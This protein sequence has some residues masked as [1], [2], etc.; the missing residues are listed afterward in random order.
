MPGLL[1][2]LSVS[3]IGFI[4]VFGYFNNWKYGLAFA[5]GHLIPDL[6]DFGTLGIMMK[7]LNPGKIMLHP[8][9][10]PLAKWCHT[11]S[12][13]LII[14]LIIALIFFLLYKL[15]KI[16]KSLLI[17]IIIGLVITLSAILIHLELDLFI[18]E[19]SYWV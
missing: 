4:L 12:H 5:I 8:W 14:A 7:T 13:W 17:K 3:F 1:T 2:H 6:C 9:F 18:I 16:S 15:K 10:P 11:F 19:K